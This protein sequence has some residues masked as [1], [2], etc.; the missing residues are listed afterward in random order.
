MVE[1][2]Q[3]VSTIF[4][5][6]LG[7]V[8]ANI[9]FSSPLKA[10]LHARKM[11]D[12]GSLNPIPWSIILLNCFGWSFY[13]CLR[14]DYF[15]FW[16]NFPAI[17][18]SIFY[19]LTAFQLLSTRNLKGDSTT[20]TILE[21]IFIGGSFFWG[22][23]S[24]VATI[25]L[26]SSQLENSIVLIGCASCLCTVSYYASPLTTIKQVCVTRDA[27]S[28][29]LPL[30]IA[31]LI[32]SILWVVYGTSIGDPIIYAPNALGLIFSIF[33]ILVVMTFAKW[34]KIPVSQSLRRLLT[35]QTSDGDGG[36]EVAAADVDIHNQLNL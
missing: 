17:C 5:P 1:V 15:V 27:S 25:V 32:N 19:C 8:I 9:M 31:N 35:Q 4:C 34:G 28:L 26:P 30:I 12:L 21:V 29:Y 6:L 13:G 22:I 3:W 20:L 18:L 11:K 23:I 7:L 24:M 10:V 2:P 33:Q 14:K 16:S 36:G